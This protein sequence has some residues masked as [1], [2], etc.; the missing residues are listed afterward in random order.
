MLFC[1][2]CEGKDFEKIVSTTMGIDEDLTVLVLYKCLEC[3]LLKLIRQ[4][5][6]TES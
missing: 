6:K 4:L 3:G 1:T 5:V 2:N